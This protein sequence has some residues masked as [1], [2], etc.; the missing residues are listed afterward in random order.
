MWPAFVVLTVLDAVIGAALPPAGDGWDGIGAALFAA[1]VNLVA[2]VLLSVPLRLALRRRRPD[3]PKV[4]AA[5]YAGTTTMLALTALLLVLGALHHGRLLQDRA[6]MSD[7]IRRAQAYIGDRAPDRFRRDLQ[8]V[9]TFTI[10]A[11]SIYRMCVPSVD[12]TQTYCVIVRDRLP[13][14]RSVSFAGYEPNALFGEG[15]N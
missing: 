11:G 2:I 6:T 14:A 15:V 9:S 13:F 8:Y 12:R 1:V 7:A 5:D 10:Q 4:V 3:L